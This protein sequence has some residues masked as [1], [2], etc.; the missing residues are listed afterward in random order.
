MVAEQVM[1]ILAFETSGPVPMLKIPDN[2]GL[3]ISSRAI[4]VHVP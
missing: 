1:P 3:L 2:Y 4:P